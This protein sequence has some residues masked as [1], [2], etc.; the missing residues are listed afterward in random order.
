MPDQTNITDFDPVSGL[1]TTTL[2]SDHDRGTLD[3]AERQKGGLENEPMTPGGGG[4]TPPPDP[5]I[6]SLSPATS[7]LAAG[8]VTVT[9]TGTNFDAGSTVEVDDAAIATVFVSA[10]SL[11]AEFTPDAEGSYNFTVRNTSGEESNN[12]AF[13]VTA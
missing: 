8:A 10:T 9:V 12:S 1:T 4:S 7:S 13:T 2:V 5:S 3:W 6:T 11:T